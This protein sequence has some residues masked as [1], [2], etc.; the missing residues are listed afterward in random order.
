MISFVV[1]WT[2]KTGC[3]E[4]ALVGLQQL[5]QAV[6]QEPGTLMYLV[7]T[8]DPI[9]FT[10]AQGDEHESLPTPSPQEVIFIEQ[11]VDENAF[12]QHVH[13]TA[14]QQ[15]LSEYGDLFLFSNG[16]PF[17]TIEFLKRQAGFIRPEASASC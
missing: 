10:C 3:N 2:I 15:F 9:Q 7:N 12:C 13:G 11:Y 8:P 1:K 17:V 5:A 16:Q 6:A 14:F 4:K